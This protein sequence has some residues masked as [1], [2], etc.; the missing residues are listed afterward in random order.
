[1]IPMEM[2][3]IGLVVN[4]IVEQIMM[5]IAITEKGEKMSRCGDEEMDELIYYLDEFLKTHKVSELV[6]LVARAIE[7]KEWEDETD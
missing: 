2:Y 7:D 4:G 1:M 6:S 3:H 5:V